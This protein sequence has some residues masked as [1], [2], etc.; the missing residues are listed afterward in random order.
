MEDMTLTEDLLQNIGDTSS[1]L[2]AAQAGSKERQVEA[3]IY[4]EQLN[5]L[6]AIDEFNH[7]RELDFERLEIERS[8][9]EVERQKASNEK[10]GLWARIGLTAATLGAE[11]W[12]GLTYLKAN[13]KFGGM[14]GKDGKGW[15]DSIKRIKL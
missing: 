10:F 15:F 14:V 3:A 1:R 12:F 6:A 2:E 8:R 13:L 4:R 7:K 11:A 5:A 9:L